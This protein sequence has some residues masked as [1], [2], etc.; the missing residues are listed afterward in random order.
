VVAAAMQDDVAV[1]IVYPHRFSVEVGRA[2]VVTEL[3]DGE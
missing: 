1:Y 3:A 2:V